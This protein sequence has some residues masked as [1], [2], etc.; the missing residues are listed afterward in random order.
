[1][2]PDALLEFSS[3]QALTATANSAN[4]IDREAPTN[5]GS[6]RRIHAYL[7]FCG[8]APGGTAP[9]LTAA[10]VGADDAAF[11]SNKIT[12]GSVTPSLTAGSVPARNVEIPIASHVPKRFY[13][14]EYTVGGSSP[15]MTVTAGLVEDYQTNPA[16]PLS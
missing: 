1:M 10:L 2:I 5:L 12:I 8:V 4:V 7:S 3:A 13:R 9:T 16:P 15:T 6:G 14:M 11:T